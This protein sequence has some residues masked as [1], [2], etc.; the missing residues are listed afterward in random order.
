M[1]RKPVQRAGDVLS[2]LMIGHQTIGDDFR[3][4]LLEVLAQLAQK[5]DPVV[6]TEKDRLACA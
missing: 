1:A 3:Q 2:T 6:I 4:F 5:E